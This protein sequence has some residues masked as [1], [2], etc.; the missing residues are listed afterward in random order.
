LELFPNPDKSQANLNQTFWHNQSVEE[1]LVKNRIPP[2]PDKNST[3]IY[4]CHYNIQELSVVS[5]SATDDMSGLPFPN[6]TGTE[7][8]YLAGI[9]AIGNVSHLFQDYSS[10]NDKLLK[11]SLMNS[12]SLINGKSMLD[13]LPSS[14]LENMQYEVNHSLAGGG[15]SLPF[16]SNTV[17]ELAAVS[18]SPSIRIFEEVERF[19]SPTLKTTDDSSLQSRQSVSQS[20]PH[21][22]QSNVIISTASTEQASSD[23]SSN[24]INDPVHSDPPPFS[25]SPLPFAML[26]TT[27]TVVEEV[28]MSAGFPLSCQP[29]TDNE[30]NILT[31]KY[32]RTNSSSNNNSTN[33][34][35]N[36][37]NNN[38]NSPAT[39]VSH[40][41]NETNPTNDIN[42][43]TVTSQDKDVLPQ[44]I[45]SITT[46][47]S[48]SLLSPQKGNLKRKQDNDSVPSTPLQH[49][50][51]IS[52]EAALLGSTSKKKVRFEE[53][54]STPLSSSF[55]LSSSS[56]SVLVSPSKK[57]SP[58]S[59][60]VFKAVS[61]GHTT[62]SHHT[63]SRQSTSSI[64]SSSSSSSLH[65]NGKSFIIDFNRSNRSRPELRRI[66][67]TWIGPLPTNNNNNTTLDFDRER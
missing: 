50:E 13:Q 58:Q 7:D 61:K 47:T 14:V 48:T 32:K 2:Q 49:R 16:H 23:T 19:V 26:S 59:L 45:H 33:I 3:Y 39:I 54:P 35:S 1:I 63:S 5:Q 46:L 64:S 15:L 30:V 67:P 52:G 17:A 8:S 57:L 53:A 31:V 38:N 44:S 41:I 37:N 24:A 55:S 21:Q 25:S 10:T 29:A 56:S 11:E 28:V 43:T 18:K 4:Y 22:H 12:N 42:E 60:A 51:V 34:N 66:R 40:D 27:S 36:N 62:I 9:D 6:P 20:S 65:H